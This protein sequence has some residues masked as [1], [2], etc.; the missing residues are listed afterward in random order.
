MRKIIVYGIATILAFG[1][2]FGVD[3]LKPE[4]KPLPTFQEFVQRRID[5]NQKGIALIDYLIT[6]TKLKDKERELKSVNLRLKLNEGL[7]KCYDLK[8]QLDKKCDELER[9]LEGN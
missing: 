5:E 8:K 7:L 6:D 3:Y 2:F 4:P 9:K 1:A